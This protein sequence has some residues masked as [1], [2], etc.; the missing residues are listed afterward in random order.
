MSKKKH[1][2]GI[3]GDDMD[4]IDERMKKIS[5]KTGSEFVNYDFKIEFKCKNQKQN[6]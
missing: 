1:L 2:Q 4:Y 3:D 5:G 6:K